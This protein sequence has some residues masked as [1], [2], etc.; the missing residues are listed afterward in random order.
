[1]DAEFRPYASRMIAT[2]IA[3]KDVVYINISPSPGTVKLNKAFG[4]RLFSGGQVAFLPAFNSVPPSDRV[5]E[6]HAELADM[7]ELTDNERY[8]LQEHAALGCLSLI[9]ICDG[10]AL[11]VV[12]KPRRILRGLIPCC[13]VVYC[14]SHVDLVRCAGAL[15]RFLLRRGKLLCLVDAMGPV[16]GLSGRY[17]PKKGIKY[18]KGPKQPSPG[19]LTFTEMVLFGS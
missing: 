19:D 13:Q 12:L 6:V 2:V 9:C 10:V 5:L 14:R 8:I 15:G 18:F 16:P 7:A 4:F 11:P 1:M 17:F 3:R